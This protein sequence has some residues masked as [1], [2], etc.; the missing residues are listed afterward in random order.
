MQE[1]LGSKRK[2]AFIHWGCAIYLS[3]ED[4]RHAAQYLHQWANPGTCW[5][6]LCQG[7]GVNTSHHRRRPD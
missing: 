5:A 4:I 2:V 6:V 3:D 7:A 1:I